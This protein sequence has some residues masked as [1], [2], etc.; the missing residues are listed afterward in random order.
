MMEAL[1]RLNELRFNLLS[2]LLAIPPDCLILMNEE[3]SPLNRD[4]AVQHL[5]LLAGTPASSTVLAP[6]QPGRVQGG[7]ERR[8][9][10]FDRE[11][12][13]AEP[14]EVAMHLRID[15]EMVLTEAP[16]NRSFSFSPSTS[17]S[18]SSFLLALTM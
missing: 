3:G 16:L 15:E 9:Y 14:E 10:V 2:P 17:M 7:T 8:I 13:D 12:L 18:S 6:P 5:A 11:H 1:R 4:E